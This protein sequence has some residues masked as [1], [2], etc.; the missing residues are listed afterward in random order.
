MDRAAWL[1]P[2]NLISVISLL[3]SLLAVRYARLQ[4]HA[5]QRTFLKVVRIGFEAGS[6]TKWTVAL[7]N[8]G[9]AVALN[10]RVAARLRTAL[11]PDPLE[12]ETKLK[13]WPID[14]MRQA[15]GQYDIPPDSEPSYTFANLRTI[16]YL[17]VSWRSA[18]G[19]RERVAWCIEGTPRPASA[20][21]RFLVWALAAR[22]EAISPLRR[23]Q[24]WLR[25]RAAQ[26]QVQT[27]P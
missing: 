15:R 18:T 6:T 17:W 4:A 5:P 26:A 27:K 13:V 8:V 24:W 12:F 3:A 21:E 9:S 19:A 16:P 1:Q 7:R 23:V 2:S 14:A 22:S 25:K 10:V 20:R 11:L